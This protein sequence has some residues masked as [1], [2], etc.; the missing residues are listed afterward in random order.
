MIQ[1]S[2]AGFLPQGTAATHGSF[3]V[4]AAGRCRIAIRPL[5]ALRSNFRN[6]AGD[7]AA[8]A[9]DGRKVRIAD[10][11]SPAQWASFA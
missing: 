4:F 8:G 5:S 2:S 11:V 3:P 6:D 9:A 1:L 10:T 7:E